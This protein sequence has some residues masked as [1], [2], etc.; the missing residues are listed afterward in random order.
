VWPREA[1]HKGMGGHAVIK[2]LVAL[3]GTVHDCSVVSE[4]PPGA[5]FGAAAVALTPQ[6]LMVPG[7]RDGKPVPD[8]PMTIS[9]RFADMG[10]PIGSH[11]PGLGTNEPTGTHMV[12]NLAW[13]SAPSFADMALAYPAAG[14]EQRVGGHVVLSCRLTGDGQLHSCDVVSEQPTGAGFR[15]AAKKL[16]GRFSAPRTFP[17]GRPLKDVMVHVPITFAPEMLD[18]VEPQIHK[19]KWTHLPD[20]NALTAAYPKTARAANV[21]TGKVVL[22]CSVQADGRLGNCAVDSQ[23][24]GGMGFDQA[25]LALAPEFQVGLWT[26]DGLPTVGGHLR[27]PVRYVMPG[28]QAPAPKP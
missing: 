14:R 23:D 4:S 24:P 15:G 1:L 28:S 19:P 2:C 22:S 7:M 13:V 26:E 20:V 3:Q 8:A 21:T 27:L 18:A 12:F 25:A 10:A 5:G 6:F 11:L 9:I 16:V 17:D